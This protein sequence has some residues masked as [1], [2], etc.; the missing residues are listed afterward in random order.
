[1]LINNKVLV[2]ETTAGIP[3]K[4]QGDA[5]KYDCICWQL[6]LVII[7]YADL[8]YRVIYSSRENKTIDCRWLRGF[9]VG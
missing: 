8:E 7:K 2:Q 3:V 1:M 9:S 6:L 5:S 4:L